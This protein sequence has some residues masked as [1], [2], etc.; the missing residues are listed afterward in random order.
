MINQNRTI[1]GALDS[2][3]AR[4]QSIKTALMDISHPHKEINW[5]VGGLITTLTSK[6]LCVCYEVIND[7]N[8]SQEAS[9]IDDL[10][11][12]QSKFNDFMDRMV[13]NE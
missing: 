5:A 3:L 7:A 2:S 8:T 6:L 9:A 4:L 12:I 10:K 11:L 13:N 1:I